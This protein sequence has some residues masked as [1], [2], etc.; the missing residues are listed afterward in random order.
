[1]LESQDRV[2]VER[3]SESGGWESGG[4]I[5]RGARCCRVVHATGGRLADG[6][7]PVGLAVVGDEG[8]GPAAG[9][10]E[11]V[12]ALVPSPD[13]SPS[14]LVDVPLPTVVV[15]PADDELSSAALAAGADAYLLDSLAPEQLARAIFLLFA[16]SL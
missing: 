11:F 13:G 1:M 15:G 14:L 2:G 3:W 5:V 16:G 10:Q 12:V 4:R 6:P 7:D 8:L 9:V